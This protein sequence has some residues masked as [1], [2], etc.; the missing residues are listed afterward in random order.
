[1]VV[2]GG[3]DRLRMEYVSETA[4][5]VVGD[6]VVTSGIDGIYPKGFVIGR[7]E[8]VEKSGGAYQTITVEPAVDFSSLEEVLVVADADA[9]AATRAEEPRSEGRRGCAGASPSR[10]RCRR[11]WRGCRPR[12][13]RGGSGA[14]RRRLRGADVRTGHRAADRHVRRAD[15][16]RAV[17][18][19]SSASAG[20]PRRSS[21]FWPGWSGR[22]SSWPSRCRG[23]WCSLP[24]RVAARVV[25]IGL[26]ALL[27]LRAFRDAL[28]GGGRAGGWATR[29]VGVLAF[30]LAELLPGAVERRRREQ[31]RLRR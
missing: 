24:R 16:G 14:G 31:K 29:V 11:R 10:S 4:D 22:S 17:E 7:V 5:V 13:R 2:G 25:F 12:H 20:W 3:D 8:S 28:C 9:G 23:S 18:R 15:P 6:S 19:R 30:Q 27:D 26:Y 21:G 1:M